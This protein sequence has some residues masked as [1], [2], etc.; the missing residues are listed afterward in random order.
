MS[1]SLCADGLLVPVC[2]TSTAME[3]LNVCKYYLG[4]KD[5]GKRR[6]IFL[7]MA[8]DIISLILSRVCLAYL[9]VNFFSLLY[10]DKK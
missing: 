3:G 8:F 4:R 6:L 10:L 1:H 9:F 7:F 5:I 2:D